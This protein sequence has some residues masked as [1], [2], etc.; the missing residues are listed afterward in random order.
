MA[1]RL[2]L[3]LGKRWKAIVQRST[4]MTMPPPNP[5]DSIRSDRLRRTNVITLEPRRRYNTKCSMIKMTKTTHPKPL[6]DRNLR[7][8]P[9]QRTITNDM[10]LETGKN[11]QERRSLA[12]PPGVKSSLT[13]RRHIHARCGSVIGASSTCQWNQHTL[14]IP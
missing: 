5:N 4:S 6:T 8:L 2:R 1:A 12:N 10:N 3:C 7:N 14:R 9:D 13:R 11:C